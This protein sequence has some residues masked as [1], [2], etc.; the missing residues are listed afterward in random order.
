[1]SAYQ[2]WHFGMKVVCVKTWSSR[3]YGYGDE[4]GPVAGNTY[5]IREIGYF[6]SENQGHLQ[7]R[8]CEIVNKARPYRDIGVREQSF[9]ASRFRPVQ[10][11]ATDISI[12]TALLNPSEDETFRELEAE[13]FA[14][15]PTEVPFR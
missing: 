14:Y 3:G 9:R 8:L 11:R 6:R 7:V 4:I 15:E 1:M 2:D 5:T 13:Q 12:F 10:N